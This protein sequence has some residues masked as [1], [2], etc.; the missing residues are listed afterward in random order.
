MNNYKCPES[1]KQQVFEDSDPLTKLRSHILS[2][3]PER[4]GGVLVR[5]NALRRVREHPHLRARTEPTF[6]E[7]VSTPKLPGT[8]MKVFMCLSWTLIIPLCLSMFVGFPGFQFMFTVFGSVPQGL[9]FRSSHFRSNLAPYCYF[10]NS[11]GHS[12][13]RVKVPDAAFTRPGN[14][15]SVLF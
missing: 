5:R 11:I 15:H 1:K 3:G 6:R 4:S 9:S 10:V 8:Y 2:S 14:K 7:V 12:F 13:H